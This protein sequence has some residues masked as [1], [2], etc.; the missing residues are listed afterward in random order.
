MLNSWS[1][2]AKDRPSFNELVLTVRKVILLEEGE[3][4]V[5]I[6]VTYLNVPTSQSY[7]YP[8]PVDPSSYTSSSIYVAS[9]S[10]IV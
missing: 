7:L 8:H 1:S 3:Q 6:D 9:K 10:T 2:E 5:G 4:K